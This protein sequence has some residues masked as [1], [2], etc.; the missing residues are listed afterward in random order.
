MLSNKTNY[1]SEKKKEKIDSVYPLLLSLPPLQ[2]CSFFF[3]PFTVRTQATEVKIFGENEK[4]IKI[5]NCV[6]G[7]QRVL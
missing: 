6:Q 3:L 4:H 7:R 2:N 1:L 5:I